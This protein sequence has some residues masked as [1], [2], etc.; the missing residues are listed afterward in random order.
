M[1]IGRRMAQSVW[2]LSSKGITYKMLAK[3]KNSLVRSKDANAKI[4]Q[5]KHF[6]LSN[7]ST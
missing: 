1:E 7:I 3:N 6:R 5:Q 2:A 4:Y